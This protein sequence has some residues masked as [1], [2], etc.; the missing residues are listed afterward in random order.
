MSHYDVFA[1]VEQWESAAAAADKPLFIF[2]HSTRCPISAAAFDAWKKWLNDHQDS[3]IRQALVHVVEHRPVSNAV[4][5]R[6]GI[7]HASPQ[8]ILIVDGKSVWNTSHWHITYDSLEE[9]LREHCGK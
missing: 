8:A 6:T 1:T 9:H 5:G 7:T 4:A 2:K 3:G